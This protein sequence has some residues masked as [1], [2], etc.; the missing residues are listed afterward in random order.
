[1][2]SF[3]AGQWSNSSKSHH[4]GNV[5]G[6]NSL[7]D[8]PRFVR[9][10]E[11]GLFDAK[12]MATATFPLESGARGISSGRR[13]H[14]GRGRHR[15]CF[16]GRWDALTFVRGR[17]SRVF[18][19]AAARRDVTGRVRLRVVCSRPVSRFLTVARDYTGLSCGPV[20]TVEDSF[21]PQPPQNRPQNR[22]LDK[23]PIGYA[24][25][26]WDETLQV[27]VLVPV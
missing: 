2:I 9:L 17:R 5:A 26:T 8:L 14:D 27:V 19:T 11:A 3:P 6:A 12:S 7:R 18:R 20:R 21:G 4:P 23:L 24:P 10:I 1:M 25:M 22:H 15:L 16:I 13:P